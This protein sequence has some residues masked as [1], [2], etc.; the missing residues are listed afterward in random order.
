MLGRVALAAR[1]LV[2]SSNAVPVQ[3]GIFQKAAQVGYPVCALAICMADARHKDLLCCCCLCTSTGDV[4]TL[5]RNSIKAHPQSHNVEFNVTFSQ[6]VI[7]TF[8]RGTS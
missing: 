2:R 8:S 6:I 4:F 5:T 7:C 1:S 3:D